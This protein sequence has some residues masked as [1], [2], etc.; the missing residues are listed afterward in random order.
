MPMPDPEALLR[1]YLAAY[2]AKDLDAIAA[3]LSDQV[4]LRDWHLEAQGKAAVL[5]E[6]RRN[7]EEARSLRI[8][9]ET[10]FVS[11]LRAAAQLR[12]LVNDEIDLSV[13][14]VLSFDASG[15]ISAVRAYKG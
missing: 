1:Q 2:A 7:F 14:D 9:V 15:M 11:G 12:I 3:M 6:T 5:R 13:V 10:V 4:H 8:T